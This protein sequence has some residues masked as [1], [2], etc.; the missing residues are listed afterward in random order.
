MI[1]PAEKRATPRTQSEESSD[2]SVSVDS[3]QQF[4]PLHGEDSTETTAR[5]NPSRCSLQHR[6]LPTCAS[7]RSRQFT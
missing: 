6:K 1:S 7:M 3:K 4:S 5:H 2:A